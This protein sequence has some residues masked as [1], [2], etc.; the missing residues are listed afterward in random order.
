MPVALKWLV[1]VLGRGWP[2]P[3]KVT[4]Y[5]LEV[6]SVVSN[7]IVLIFPRLEPLTHL[8]DLFFYSRFTFDLWWNIG[9]RNLFCGVILFVFRTGHEQTVIIMP[10]P[11]LHTIENSNEFS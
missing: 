5:R 11:E 6:L 3:F 2:C 4:K 8:N 10:G 9:E 7:A 1:D